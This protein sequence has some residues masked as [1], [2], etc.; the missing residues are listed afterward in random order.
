MFAPDRELLSA[1]EGDLTL[2]PEG[3]SSLPPPRRLDSVPEGDNNVDNDNG[4]ASV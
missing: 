3:A 1:S 2:A 4:T